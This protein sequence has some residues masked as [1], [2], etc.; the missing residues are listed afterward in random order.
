[1]WLSYHNLI[2]YI[3]W[4]ISNFGENSFI[5]LIMIMNND[6]EVQINLIK[7]LQDKRLRRTVLSLM[8][9]SVA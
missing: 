2:H 7:I 4:N 9:L 3:I 1:M 6:E 8:D 5:P